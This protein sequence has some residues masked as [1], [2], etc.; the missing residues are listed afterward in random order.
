MMADKDYL[1]SPDDFPDGEDPKKIQNLKGATYRQLK[2]VQL[3]AEYV[4]CSLLQSS[5][6]NCLDPVQIQ[7]SSGVNAKQIAYVEPSSPI[8]REVAVEDSKEGG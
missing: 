4:F 3:V 2:D 7:T 1:L 8:A 5:R 6:L